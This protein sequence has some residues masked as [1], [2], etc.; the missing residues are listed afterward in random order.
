MHRD[1]ANAHLPH[2]CTLR[3]QFSLVCYVVAVADGSC[4]ADL[5]THDFNNIRFALFFFL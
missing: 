4:Y 1:D 5:N 2:R 3:Q